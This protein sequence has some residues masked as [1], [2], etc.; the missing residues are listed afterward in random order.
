MMKTTNKPIKTKKAMKQKM[1]MKYLIMAAL[2]IM[3]AIMAG[4]KKETPAA[5]ENNIVTLT[6]SV[7]FSEDESTKAL[8][9]DYINK[10]VVKTFAEGES[11]AVIYKSGENTLKAVSSPLPAGD[12]G[13]SATFEVALS[14]PNENSPI[15]I[16]YPA[17]RA[18]IV[19]TSAIIDNDDATINYYGFD[20]QNGIL[21]KLAEKLDLCTF[22]GALSGYELPA[23]A[24][25]TNRLAIL[26]Y[27]LYDGKGTPD[28]ADD[29]PITESIT[30]LTISDGTNIY[31]VK[32]CDADGHIYAAIRPTD[33]ANIELFATDGTEYYGKSLTGKTY[34]AGQFYNI[35]NRMEKLAVFTVGIEIGKKV[36]VVFAPGNLQAT[37]DGSSWSWA[38][39]ANQ[40]DYIG[41]AAG[42]TSINGVG[43]ISGTG[44]VDLFGWVGK[45]ST[46]TGAALYGISNSIT[47]VDYGNV[48]NE[49]QK[50]DW[51]NTIGPAWRTLTNSECIYLLHDRASGSTVNGINNALYTLATINTDV[52]G[53]NG[54]ILFPDGITVAGDEAT[55]W[56]SIN[57]ASVWGTKCTS[58]QWTALAAKGCVFL[59][60][61]GWR[62]ASSV[63]LVD[64][65]GLYWSSTGALSETSYNPPLVF[66]LGI[67]FD[68]K[69]LIY[70]DALQR[71]C[72]GSVRLVHEL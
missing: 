4:C 33:S 16:I 10:T 25:L 47:S 44:T 29:E 1:T 63:E 64:S 12:Y 43:T 14:S 57:S 17:A 60:A 18:K 23:T 46:W 7:G 49:T 52:K 8:D 51:G 11:I 54:L 39:A 56:G 5:E 32:G 38:F 59:P 9:V 21:N 50:S 22:D 28:K 48:S 41:D 66:A 70:N 45:S 67:D 55:S 19:E 42:N 6:V 65:A 58:A 40:W 34:A 36:K 35:T 72:G 13:K 15:R 62:D 71:N 53:V 37:W 68:E 2:V 3:G 24:S 20:N 61:A 31:T 30:K 26:S 69:E 27:T